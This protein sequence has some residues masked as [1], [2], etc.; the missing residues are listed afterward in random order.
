MNP[1]YSKG[2]FF[3]SGNFQTFITNLAPQTNSEQAMGGSTAPHMNIPYV[4][5]VRHPIISTNIAVNLPIVQDIIVI[6]QPTLSNTFFYWPPNDLYYY[7]IKCEEISTQLLNK[8]SSNM[9]NINFN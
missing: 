2:Q 9:S 7:H 3:G 4:T 5:S 8:F 1:I 6:N